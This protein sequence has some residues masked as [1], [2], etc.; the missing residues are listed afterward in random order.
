MPQNRGGAAPASVRLA[1]GY[2]KPPLGFDE[3]RGQSAAESAY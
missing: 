1:E 3:N 2:G